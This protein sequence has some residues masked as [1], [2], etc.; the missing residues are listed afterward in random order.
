MANNYPANPN[1][2]S[3]LGFRFHVRKLPNVSFFTQQAI[4]PTVSLGTANVPTPFSNIPVP[5]DHLIYADF[6]LT[7]KVDE[8]LTNYIEVYNWMVSMGFP[9]SFD[10]YTVN[11]RY[12]LNSGMYSDGVVEILN[13]AKGAVAEVRFVDMYPTMLCDVSFDTR[14]TDV[15][16]IEATV[17]FAYR[18]F[19]TV[20]L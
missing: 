12:Q 20:K 2:L 4:I 16:Y 18:S 9:E 15:N 13:S 6:S 10:Q 7:F 3:P 17:Q 19:T 8:D 11:P 5:G 1:F 14:S